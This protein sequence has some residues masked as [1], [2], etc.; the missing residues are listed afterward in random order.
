MSDTTSPRTAPDFSTDKVV[1]TALADLQFSLDQRLNN[2][3]SSGLTESELREFE[4]RLPAYYDAVLTRGPGIIDWLIAQLSTL[5][6]P[7]EICAVVVILLA[8]RDIRAAQG[9]VVAFQNAADE[10]KLLGFQLALR[11]GPID[12]LAEALQKWLTSPPSKLSA[13]AAEALAYHRRL[14]PKASELTTLLAAPD[15]MVRRAA[16]RATALAH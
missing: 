13:L 14:T 8:S 2:V 1:Q 12:L 5:E 15:P 9:I 16:W 11:R 3:R 10:P 6:S 7:T 4:R